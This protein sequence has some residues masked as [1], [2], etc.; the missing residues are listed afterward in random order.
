MVPDLFSMEILEKQL[1]Q[2][3]FCF[4]VSVLYFGVLQV[5]PCVH[6]VSLNLCIVVC[7]MA[8]AAV[9]FVSFEFGPSLAGTCP[10]GLGLNFLSPM[11]EIKAQSARPIL[12]KIGQA[13]ETMNIHAWHTRRLPFQ[14]WTT[15]SLEVQCVRC[16]FLQITGSNQTKKININ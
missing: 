11:F 1:F 13:K 12:K 7:C 6:E 16:F 10:I 9:V 15:I 14:P 5:H 8:V 3:M 4:F 2:G